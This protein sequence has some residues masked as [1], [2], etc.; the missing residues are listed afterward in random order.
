MNFISIVSFFEDVEE[1]RS[2]SIKKIRNIFYLV[3]LNKSGALKLKL[4]L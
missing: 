4:F 3:P 2:K 1:S